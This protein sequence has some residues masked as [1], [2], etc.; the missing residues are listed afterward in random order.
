MNIKIK[1]L[2]IN[3]NDQIKALVKWEN[4]P[5]LFHLI[6]PVLDKDAPIEK[7]TF[8]SLKESFL[9]SPDYALSI[10]IIFDEEKPIGNFS[11]MLDPQHL[12][13]K[14]EG[15]SWL[16]LTLGDSDYWGKGVSKIAMERFEEESRKRGASRIELGVFEFNERAIS[17]YKKL[18]YKVIGRINKF[19]YW[20]GKYWDDIR[21]EKFI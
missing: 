2:D 16:G 6:V 14:V 17:F 4:D 7:K 12:M 15:T 11:L 3:S 18:G 10:Y 19:T 5:E 8:E 13:K 9:D 20:N 21:M 1:Q